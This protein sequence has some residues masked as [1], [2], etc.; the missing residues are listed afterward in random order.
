MNNN[1]P[2]YSKSKLVQF[3]IK[4][5]LYRNI[6]LS[7]VFI[8]ILVLAVPLYTMNVYDRVLPDFDKPTL[9]VL[10]L[11]VLLALIFDLILKIL[12]SSALTNLADQVSFEVE[13]KFFKDITDDHDF[14]H[15]STGQKLNL[16]H[17]LSHIRIF[18]ITKV[19]PFLFDLPFFL[20]FLSVIYL[21]S[22]PLFYVPLLGALFF[23]FLGFA[24]LL[25]AS[26][27]DTRKMQ[28]AQEKTNLLLET[29]QGFDTLRLMCAADAS[30]GRWKS[31]LLQ[32]IE[33]EKP[34]QRTQNFLMHCASFIALIV[35]ASVVFLGA[36]EVSENTLTL[37]GLIAVSILS[38]RAL[39]PISALVP[40]L[41]GYQGYKNAKSQLHSFSNN[42]MKLP[43]NKGDLSEKNLSGALSLKEISYKY[44]GQSQNAL[45]DI[46]LEIPKEERLAVIGASG[47]GKSTLIKILSGILDIQK[48]HVLWDEFQ[49]EAVLQVQRSRHIGLSSQDDFFFAGT[50]F[51][52]VFM[53]VNQDFQNNQT[54]V[55]EVCFLS[56]LDLF[57]E[58][59]GYG[60][61]TPILEKGHNLSTGAKQSISL[62]RAMMHDPKILILDEPL[63]GLD[64]T[65]EKRL[66]DQLPKW[67]NG[68]TFIMV[69]H[70][71]SLLPL[72]DQILLLEKGGIKAYG[73]RDKI[74]E[75]L[76]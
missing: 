46:T 33:C 42:A 61:D 59:T 3:L 14:S 64:F 49:L 32:N 43:K 15:I 75:A 19:L 17:Y 68:K 31:S 28:A 2:L 1:I 38:S 55:D 37:G 6:L 16:F 29:F 72:V 53:G 5:G 21:I 41:S 73:L 10:F 24:G 22:P 18:Q 8:N 71:T 45:S 57:M 56:G 27:F 4:T 54:H 7:T 30:L 44:A 50:L 52:N 62:A 34:E 65:I 47:A 74:I 48:G 60:W 35:S 20:L 13:S 25:V 67:L 26:H 70:R 12:R 51:E 58:Q 76:S 11:G 36:F 9:L 23:A 40:I 39:A 63:N 66:I 69:T